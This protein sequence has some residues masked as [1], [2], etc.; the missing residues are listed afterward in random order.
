MVEF[1]SVHRT[2]LITQPSREI[3]MPARFELENDNLCVIHVSGK[4]SVEEIQ[5][6][7]AECEKVI[8]REGNIRLL[9]ILEGFQGWLKQPGWD[10]SSFPQRNDPFITRFAIVGDEQWRDMAYVFTLKGLRPIPI[11]FF[12]TGQL[13]TARTWLAE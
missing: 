2:G 4:L 3:N 7:Q 12:E 10:D 9:V 13:E 5:Q 1:M 6:A 11:E 8:Q